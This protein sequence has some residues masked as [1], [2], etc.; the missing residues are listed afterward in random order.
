MKA[1]YATT[2]VKASLLPFGKVH[3]PQQHF[4]RQ[5]SH[6]R[7]QNVRRMP[8]QFFFADQAGTHRN[9]AHAV[10]LGRTNVIGMIAD[11]RDRTCAVDPAF[12]A[13]VSHSRCRPIPR[14]REPFRRKRRSAGSGGSRRAPSSSSRCA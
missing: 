5:G 3:L 2:I 12:A 11:E 10:R 7:N 9:R 14:D 13:R 4:N 8:R 6:I 1:L